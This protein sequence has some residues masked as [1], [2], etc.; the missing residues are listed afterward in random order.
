MLMDVWAATTKELVFGFATYYVYT[1]QSISFLAIHNLNWPSLMRDGIPSA[2]ELTVFS[3]LQVMF[4]QDTARLHQA[5]PTE[6][7]ND[8][9]DS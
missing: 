4:R 1:L 2:E 7:N 6:H 3:H 9:Y 8:Q 5:M